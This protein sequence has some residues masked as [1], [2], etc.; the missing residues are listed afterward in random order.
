MHG[1]ENLK[2]L[3]ELLDETQKTYPGFAPEEKQALYRMALYK[4]S[5]EEIHEAVLQAAELK[6][7]EEGRKQLLEQYTESL[8]ELPD[9]DVAQLEQY[10]FQLQQMCHEQDKA[11]GILENILKLNGI[12]QEQNA[13]SREPEEVRMAETRGNKKENGRSK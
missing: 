13:I 6:P 12:H 4:E 2:K 11:L 9:E 10:I 1:I 7:G 3:F 8:P 5:F